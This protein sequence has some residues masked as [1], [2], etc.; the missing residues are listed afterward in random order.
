MQPSQSEIQREFETLRD[1]R[2]R[3]TSQGGPGTLLLDP[4]LPTQPSSPVSPLSSQNSYWGSGVAESSTT[5]S[6]EE[7]GDNQN[8]ATEDPFHLFWVPARLHPELAPSEFR[9]FLKE[10]ARAPPEGS[11]AALS[12]TTSASSLGRRKSMLSKQYRPR[13]NDGVEDEEDRVVSLQRNR[14]RI[15][16]GPQ[17]TISDL[18]K[19]EELAEEASQSDD[20][21]RLRSVLRRSLSL[22]LSP[23]AIDE[24]EMPDTGDDADLPII[25]PGRNQIVRR[26]ARTKIRKPGLAG[27][28]GGHRFAA[29]TR[30]RSGGRAATID[31]QAS[32]DISSSDHDHDHLQRPPLAAAREEEESEESS[33]VTHHRRASYSE[34]AMIYEAYT[35]EEDEKDAPFMSGS[36][37]LVVEL[38]VSISQPEVDSRNA[39]PVLH[40]P[41]PQ[42]YLT[43]PVNQP[44]RTPSRTPSPETPSH[45]SSPEDRRYGSPSSEPSSFLS[46]S[47]SPDKRS[48]EKKRIFGKWAGDKGSK[49]NGKDKLEREKE[50]EKEK[51][52]SFFGSLFGG[53]KKKQEEPASSSIVGGSGPATAAALLGA[54]KSAKGF[55]PP[56]SPQLGNPYARYPI[57]VE[58]AVYRL[59]HIKL[60]N[61]RRP[62]YEQVLISN[63]MFWYLGVINKTQQNPAQ[64]QQTMQN[65]QSGQVGADGSMA[66]VSQ[67][68]TP[69]QVGEDR[70]EAEERERQMERERDERARAERQ[71]REQE[72]ERIEQKKETRRGSL[73]KAAAPGSSTGRRAEMPVKGP[74]YGLQHQA[75]EQ[76]Y[77]GGMGMG[78]GSGSA[79]MSRTP[80]SP[81]IGGSS[82]GGGRAEYS[83][84]QNQSS[85]SS[86]TAY[87][88]GQ[89]QNNFYPRSGSPPEGGGGGT[90]S[91]SNSSSTIVRG[92]VGQTPPQ[93]QL[94]PGAMPAPTP[95][96]NWLS[97]SL[98]SPSQRSAPL[99]S[100]SSNY[101]STPPQSADAP[102]FGP[103]RSSRSPPPARRSAN[104]DSAPPLPVVTT[105][106]QGRSLS[107]S[108]VVPHSAPPNGNLKKKVASAT[109]LAA[110]RDRRPKSSEGRAAASF[111]IGGG[112]EEDV[113]L[114]VWQQQRR[115]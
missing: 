94:P 71:E 17:L 51:E 108:A 20:P 73:T 27:D 103:V 83:H 19:L 1:I 11:S 69:A 101:S 56:T 106:L 109:A 46:T 57:H 87:T 55:Q 61:P 60:A 25:V 75:I 44:Q 59:S 81:P 92:R 4:D 74:Q 52:S 8:D 76:E 15:Y 47:P 2:R 5:R 100:S 114:A 14:S 3:S 67:P 13:E 36:P 33:S 37:P 111:A 6:N 43:P 97:S 18:Q 98:Q 113:P 38:P 48:K 93:L 50:K 86:N 7:G 30:R 82:G 70:R 9:A 35:R 29:S 84:R 80:S 21:S 10:H 72:R 54:S 77:G 85:R 102:A 65:Q 110:E 107:A 96:Q 90:N 24:D 16:E 28:G 53:G 22:N 115:K 23:S 88:Q 42:R 66:E 39:S 104:N 105:K 26:A 89:N 41:Q 40:H 63:L 58:R 12:R 49:K 62:L 95:E 78:M 79:A 91:N 45:P 99:S 32:S 31:V 64:A 34:D 68:I 112:E